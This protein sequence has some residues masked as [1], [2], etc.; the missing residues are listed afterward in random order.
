[1]ELRNE[2]WIDL[3]GMTDTIWNED[4][5]LA[6]SKDYDKKSHKQY[7]QVWL[8]NI[9]LCLRAL[10]YKI[11]QWKDQY[12]NLD[13]DTYLNSSIIITN[14][15]Y[16][17]YDEEGNAGWNDWVDEVSEELLLENSESE[18][19]VVSSADTDPE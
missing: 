5:C 1:M 15:P 19:S 11:K 7:D 9:R 3:V 12:I 14:C 6:F 8:L 16:E 18:S 4:G 10:G 2:L 13:D 17:T